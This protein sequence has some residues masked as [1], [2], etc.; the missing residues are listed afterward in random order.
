MVEDL[1]WFGAG[2]FPSV[3]AFLFWGLAQCCPSGGPVANS[4][5][6]KTAD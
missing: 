3:K 4:T 6:T 2:D 5:N 1:S